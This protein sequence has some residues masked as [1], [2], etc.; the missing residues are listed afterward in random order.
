MQRQGA[1]KLT[2]QAFL[3]IINKCLSI[4]YIVNYFKKVNIA[5]LLSH[6]NN[7]KFVFTNKQE[8]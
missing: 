2:T 5:L 4:K 1:G 7:Y 6:I 3:Q 8:V